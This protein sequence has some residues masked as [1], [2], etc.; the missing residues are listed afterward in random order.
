MYGNLLSYR[1]DKIIGRGLTV[2]CSETRSHSMA[3]Q[4]AYQVQSNEL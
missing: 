4:T 3:A 2:R 1:R